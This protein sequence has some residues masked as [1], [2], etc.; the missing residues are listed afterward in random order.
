MFGFFP[1]QMEG[2]LPPRERMKG[3]GAAKPPLTLSAM[4]TKCPGSEERYPAAMKAPTCEQARSQRDDYV[5]E[6]TD[7]QHV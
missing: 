2:V 1:G 4:M 6:K 3:V 5:R 7:S